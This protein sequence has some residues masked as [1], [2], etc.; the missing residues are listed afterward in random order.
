M[1]FRPRAANSCMPMAINEYFRRW[2]FRAFVAFVCRQRAM[3]LLRHIRVRHNW[4][5][6][7]MQHVRVGRH[8][9]HRRTI[10]STAWQNTATWDRGAARQHERLLVDYR[11]LNKRYAHVALGTMIQGEL[12]FERG[13]SHSRLLPLTNRT[14]LG[15]IEDYRRAPNLAYLAIFY[16]IRE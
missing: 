5:I 16:Y 3:C 13:R 4:D 11:P 2:V 15:Y 14:V 9:F 1:P 12:W 8:L 10:F 7:L 6:R